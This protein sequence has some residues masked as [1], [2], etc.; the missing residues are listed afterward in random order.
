MKKI[1]NKLA[2][3]LA[4]SSLTLP[5]TAC[6]Y[7]FYVNSATSTV[8]KSFADQS[9]AVIKSLVLGK[10]KSTDTAQTIQDMLSGYPNSSIKNQTLDT[11]L[12]TWQEFVDRW[13]FNKNINLTGF[14]PNEEN[15]FRATGSGS[16]TQQVNT[17]KTVN[18]VLNQIG[19]VSGLNVANNRIVYNLIKSGDIK[20]TIVNFLNGTKK[21]DKNEMD[22]ITILLKNM[23]IGKDWTAPDNQAFTKTITNPLTSLLNY[24]V[25]GKWT[26]TDSTPTDKNAFK[27]FMDNWKDPNGHAYS[28]WNTDN[29]WEL[30]QDVYETWTPTDYNFYRSGVL[31]NHLF[32]QIGKDYQIIN[33]KPPAEGQDPAAY[34]DRYLGT[35]IGDHISM[36]PIG[37]DEYLM[38]D[39][40]QYLPHLLEDPSY[41][42]TLVEAVVP[43]IKQWIL[44]MNDITQGAKN[45]TFGKIFPTN[46][47]TNS[48]NVADILDTIKD[49]IF[50]PDKII[51]IVRN[52][53]NINENNDSPIGKSFAYD[54]KVKIELLGQEVPLPVLLKLVSAIDPSIVENIINTIKSLLETPDVKNAVNNILNIYNQWIKQYDDK[55][56]GI[57]FDLTQLK[58]FLLNDTNGLITIINRDL[59]PI[60][61]NIMT[62]ADPVT[63]ETYFEFYQ[64]LGGQLPNG[65]ELAPLS[66]RTDSILDLLKSNISNPDIPLGQLSLILLGNSSD[67]NAGL[68]SFVIESNNQWLADNYTNFF[69]VTNKSKGHVYNQIMTVSDDG[70]QTSNT[71]TYNFAYK[72]N[73]KTYYFWVRC[74]SLD[75][76]DNF[77][78]TKNFYFTD[79]QL[80]EI[81]TN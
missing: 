41:I 47:N 75:F 23:V 16:L 60:L 52:L 70:V 17:Y 9:S 30:D 66:F 36:S 24:L 78:G 56:T 42:I 43:I 1:F 35:I 31:I 40:Q 76:N 15:Y 80:K 74:K 26:A 25:D 46:K 51:E 8:V 59:M 68:F 13:G 49:L 72:I 3:I 55:N 20:N 39:I 19:L 69:D 79:I 65:N 71:L 48:F 63:D 54:I 34:K 53:L 29:G 6:V 50:N 32:Y 7:N 73:N 62:T 77:I 2:I 10:E 67:D 45:L 44:E 22:T 5:L 81:R 38:P 12:N 18:T 58:D 61:Y 37:L 14:N 57:N 4:T 21:T 33:P 28:Q 27:S 64:K 11:S